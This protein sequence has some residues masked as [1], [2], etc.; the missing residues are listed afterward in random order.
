MKGLAFGRGGFFRLERGNRLGLSLGR[1]GGVGG[2]VGGR[3]R[4]ASDGTLGREA[5]GRGAR[6]TSWVVVKSRADRVRQRGRRID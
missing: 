4:G 6:E 2:G 1:I 5:R 3:M